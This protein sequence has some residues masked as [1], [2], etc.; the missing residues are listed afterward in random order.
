MKSLDNYLQ[1]YASKTYDK[2]NKLESLIDF[3]FLWAKY[4]FFFCYHKNYTTYKILLPFKDRNDRTFEIE[5]RLEDRTLEPDDPEEAVKLQDITISSYVFNWIYEKMEK[6][7]EKIMDDFDVLYDEELGFYTRCEYIKFPFAFNKFLQ[8]LIIF[9]SKRK[10]YGNEPD[11]DPY[12]EDQEDTEET[13]GEG[14]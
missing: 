12:P 5:I 7:L 13:E 14:K 4:N 8:F 3:Y 9:A 6:K 1:F 10:K 11:P 2:K